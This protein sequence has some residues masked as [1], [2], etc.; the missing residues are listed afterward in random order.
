MHLKTSRLLLAVIPAIFA[1]F[2]ASVFAMA[3][4]EQSYIATFVGVGAALSSTAV[5]LKH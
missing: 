5:I 4:S 2:L 3:I 1:F